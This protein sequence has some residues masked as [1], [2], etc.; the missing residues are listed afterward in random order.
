MAKFTF[1]KMGQGKQDIEL[2]DNSPISCIKEL[3]NLNP[4]MTIMLRGEEV[5]DTDVVEDGANY[6]GVGSP[7]GAGR[8]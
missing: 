2:P 4:D 7:K 1:T 6:V 5:A 8:E 3:V